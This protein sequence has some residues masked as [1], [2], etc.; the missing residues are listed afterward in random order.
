MEQNKLGQIA[1]SYLLSIGFWSALSLLTGW[2]YLIFDQ[3][4]NL[5]ST[6]V[7]MLLL[8]ESR[9]LAFALLTPPIFY[10]VRRYAPEVHH[11]LQYLFVCCL[12]IGP[13]MV[14]YACVRWVIFPLWDPAE[15]LFVPRASN[16]PFAL[17]HDGFADII[18][19]YF[20]TLLAAHAFDYFE[21]VRNQELE[22]SEYQQALATSE[23]QALKMQIHPHFL[24]NTLHGISTLIDSD[25]KSAK[26][27]I[28][29]LSGLLRK[30]LEQSDADM[31]S[32]QEELQ[33][34]GEY[35]ELEKMRFGAR[36]NVKFSID[37]NTQKMLIPHLILQ[38][39][40]ENAIRYGVAQS[41][42]KS[43]IEIASQQTHGKLRLRIS[44]SIGVKESSGTGLGLRNTAA[45]LKYLYSEEATFSFVKNQD[46]AAIVTIVVPVLG[47]HLQSR[48]DTFMSIKIE[49][50]VNDYARIDRR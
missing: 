41:R 7:E 47:S 33:F 11:R 21:R 1:K 34:V 19:M 27:M 49:N 23:L 37:P 25:G 14:I 35:L 30:T 44:N 42:E 40:V 18:T 2:Q 6:L 28:V 5:H 50:E 39:L 36:L 3:S 31:V 12:G 32:L 29:K 17:I 13:Y 20:A 22:R 4:A 15:H 24:F 8:A 46:R 9:G 26:E 43:W 45:R 16:S 48:K 10:L 38:P